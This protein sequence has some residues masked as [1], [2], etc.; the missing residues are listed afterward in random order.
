MINVHSDPPTHEFLQV[1][2]HPAR[3]AAMEFFSDGLGR[4]RDL[5]GAPHLP[6]SLKCLGLAIFGIIERMVEMMVS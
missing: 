2:W 1:Y 5:L 6:K 4:S 3:D